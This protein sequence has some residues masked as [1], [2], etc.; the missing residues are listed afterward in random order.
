[1][2]GTT[3]ALVA[4]G[5]SL[6][7][8]LRSIVKSAST[9]LAPTRKVTLPDVIEMSPDER[10]ALDLLPS[11]I[12]SNVVPD[13]KRVLN[14]V[15]VR[16]LLVEREALDKASALIE[17]RKK[18]QRT[19]IFNSLD[20]SLAE[21]PADA[22]FDDDGFLILPGSITATGM[23][24]KFTREIRQGSVSITAEDLLAQVDA[25]LIAHDD[26]LAMTT[27]TRVIDEAKVMLHIRSCPDAMKAI[28]AATSSGKT[29]AS[30]YVRKA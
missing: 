6:P 5:K 23:S 28:A 14:D 21:V 2:S 7:E 10:H 1:M 30:C 8:I 26:Y 22:E 15:E 4:T 13:S 24:K 16:L 18:A 11:V 12:E 27:Q 25:G 9:A 3:E 17:R 19:A 20:S 29:T